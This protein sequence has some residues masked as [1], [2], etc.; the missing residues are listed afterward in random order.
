MK[1]KSFFKR[2][3]P[4]SPVAFLGRKK[5]EKILGGHIT[6]QGKVNAISDESQVSTDRDID[7]HD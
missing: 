2:R 1:F 3:L 5:A 4:Y 7:Q 6:K